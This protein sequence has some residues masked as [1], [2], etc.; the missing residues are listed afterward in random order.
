MENIFN[1]IFNT[2]GGNDIT[3]INFLAIL[4]CSLIVGLIL[5]FAYMYK[6]KY[7]KSF[8]I[9]L[10]L[11]PA[12][13]SMVILM[14]NGNIGAGV[15]VAG[16][17]SLVR[18]RSVP[19][20]AKEIG[21]IFIAMAA[22]LALGMGYVAY[23]ILFSIILGIAFI[24][25]N[26]FAFKDNKNKLLDKTMT[27]TIPEDLD[28]SGI[29]NDLFGKYTT[30]CDLIKVKSTNMGS[31]FK[32]TYNLTLKDENLEKSF[33]DELRCRNGNLE[34]VSSIQDTNNYEL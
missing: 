31:M 12:V 32:L 4:G 11:L 27:I 23:A 17:F 5:S 6:N 34:I 10:S 20:S 7:T 25:Y 9:T 29:F 2:A 16:A 13:V 33:I 3:L 24:I 14:V 18:F 26:M 8:V 28:Y 22:G 1:G 30:S 15:A 19:G 21:T